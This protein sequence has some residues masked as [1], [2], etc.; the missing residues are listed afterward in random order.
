MLPSDSQSACPALLT[1]LRWRLLRQIHAVVDLP[2]TGL[3]FVWL[4]LVLYD[5]LIGLT[6][7]WRVLSYFI[8]ALFILDFSLELT[9]AP[10]KW[11]Y[12]R[13][14]WLTLLSLILPAFSVLRMLMLFQVLQSMSAVGT[15][16]LFRLVT[17]TN[18]TL[19]A[20]AWARGRYQ[21]PASKL[22][23]LS[24]SSTNLPSVHPCA[25]L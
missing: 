16:D 22:L 9:L 23:P 8:W 15:I 24:H 4:A 21:P 14:R 13:Q 1:A 20:M 6:L 10:D 2:M 12:L 25:M 18:R 11:T 5:L 3:A 19:K 7:P 17:A